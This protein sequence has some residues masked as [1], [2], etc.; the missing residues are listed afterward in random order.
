MWIDT[1]VRGSIKHFLAYYGNKR[2]LKAKCLN[3]P[4]FV[5][6]LS[7]SLRKL[8][9]I[10]KTCPICKAETVYQVKYWTC[11][12]EETE[13]Y[14]AMQQEKMKNIDTDP[15][16]QKSL[17]F[18][19][20]ILEYSRDGEDFSSSNSSETFMSN[21][22][23]VMLFWGCWYFIFFIYKNMIHSGLLINPS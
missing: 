7:L 12:R 16:C 17:K 11:D 13:K 10:D 6:S 8:F 21:N 5:K 15:I 23:L 19:R 9:D 4:T 22:F 1:Y 18:R 14:I 2:S 20:C 3:S